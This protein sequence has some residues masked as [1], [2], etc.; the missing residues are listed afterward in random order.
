[1]DAAPIDTAALPVD[2]AERDAAVASR[3][4]DLTQIDADTWLLGLDVDSRVVPYSI[5]YLLRDAEGAL[6]VID[7]GTESEANWALLTAAIERV[8]GPRAV[9]RTIVATH[10]HRDH[11]G[12]AERLRGATGA[13]FLLHR[14]EQDAL[15]GLGGRIDEAVLE[16]WGVPPERRDELNSHAVAR[17]RHRDLVADRLLE[18]ED[19]V[20]MPGRALRIIATPGHTRGHVCLRD[21]AAR[22]FFTGDHLLPLVNP[23]VGLGGL[24]AEN[25]LAQ[26]LASLRR[27]E[28]FD[29]DI[30]CPGHGYR[31]KG[32]RVRAGEIAAH[33]SRRTDEVATIRSSIPS[34]TV[35]EVAKAVSWTAGWE[36]LRGGLLTSALRQVAM[37]IRLLDERT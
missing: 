26:Y 28:A 6:H 35:W 21:E 8:A 23:G 22:L 19:V 25:P 10:L 14:V 9:V 11:L 5:A 4:L 33:H 1:M 16:A 30:A 37:H 32:V 18:D 7:P 31:F 2:T 15:R 20:E 29:G 34:A 17:G 12:L 24:G 3:R 27:V 13:A 36:A